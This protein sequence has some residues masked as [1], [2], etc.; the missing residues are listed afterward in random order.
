M[1]AYVPWR[2]YVHSWLE[3]FSQISQQPVEEEEEKEIE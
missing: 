2:Q 1:R 3:L